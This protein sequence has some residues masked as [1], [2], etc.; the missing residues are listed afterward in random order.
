[1]FAF[2][3]CCHERLHVR[4]GQTILLGEARQVGCA[5]EALQAPERVD[6]CIDP[7]AKFEPAFL[8]IKGAPAP[9]RPR[10]SR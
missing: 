2:Q 9:F 1:M 10:R 7:G 8:S 3:H 5:D 4:L 6:G